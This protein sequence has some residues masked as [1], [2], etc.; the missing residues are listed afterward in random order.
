VIL[1][2]FIA[3]IAFGLYSAV[4]QFYLIY[5]GYD[6][7]MLGTI[8]MITNIASSILMIPGGLIADY[9]GR[10]R[11]L[12]IG[13]L[14]S[15]PPITIILFSTYFPIVAFSAAILGLSYAF[16]WPTFS[17]LFAD[18][19]DKEEMDFGFSVNAFF[20]SFSFAIGSILSWTP[21]ILNMKFN[22]ELIDSYKFT[23]G[24]IALLTLLSVIP[25]FRVKP[26]NRSKRERKPNLKIKSSRIAL[27]YMIANA[28]VAFGAGMTIQMFGY[29][30][31]KKFGIRED[32]YGTLS[33]IANIICSPTFVIAP[34][35]SKRIGT[36]M[37]IIYTQLASVPGLIF[38]TFSPNFIIASIIY[39]YRQALMN[40][41]NPL[42]G[43]LLM[44][45]VKEEERATVNSLS[46]LSWSISNALGMPIG[47]YIMDNIMVDLPPYATSAF[48]IFYVI[49]FYILMRNEAYDRS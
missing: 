47:G 45:L 1:S 37:A 42:I 36:L 32:A 31:Y 30:F 17:A 8:F 33:F 46:T 25:I 29:Y 49:I 2:N 44:K 39:I 27:K 12:I 19:M 6:G 22:Y 20:Q 7:T 9:Y 23:L 13:T 3:W 41:T 34:K 14:L 26:I 21:S 24:L 40:M 35:I 10:K 5:A 11:I 43:S 16:S 28:I 18:T 38:I 15:I 48:Y 4:F